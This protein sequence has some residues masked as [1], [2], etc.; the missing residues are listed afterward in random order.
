MTTKTRVTIHRGLRTSELELV[1][2][3]IMTPAAGKS[4][5]LPA[6]NLTVFTKPQAEVCAWGQSSGHLVLY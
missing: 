3:V 1:H 5:Q 4:H 2:N 6:I